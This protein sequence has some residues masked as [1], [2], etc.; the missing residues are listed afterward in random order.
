M[1]MKS[2]ATHA[3]ALVFGV[4]GALAAQKAQGQPMTLRGRIQIDV[5]RGGPADAP[6]SA[7][8][9]RLYMG[10]E[11]QFT[12][13]SYSVDVDFAD[14]DQE[15]ISLAD[16]TLVWNPEGRTRIM[17]GH[18]RP[19]A[20]SDMLTSDLDTVFVERAA[21]ADLMALGRMWGAMADHMHGNWGVQIGFFGAHGT[22][23]VNGDFGGA[24]LG[25]VRVHGNFLGG[26]SSSAADAPVLH[27]AAAVQFGDRPDESGFTLEP[28][29][30]FGYPAPET[31]PGNRRHILFTGLE[32]G[33]QH[34]TLTFQAEGGRTRVY[35]VS[36]GNPDLY[37]WYAQIAW[38]PTG[39]SRP[40]EAREGVFERVEPHNPLGNGG[41]GAIELGARIGQVDLNDRYL[42]GGRMTSYSTVMSWFPVKN[43]RLMA[44]YVHSD[45]RH[46]SA[47]DR[48]EDFVTLRAQYSW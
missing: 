4:Y 15:E 10:V 28:E 2:V 21:Y 14:F 9:R 27:M 44:N 35:A 12:N 7:Q 25:A 17:V 36:G 34:K 31:A 32:I 8:V 24:A 47:G 26:K 29:T 5:P 30:V 41:I 3:T 11:G 13:F 16:A 23:L 48:K 20:L 33:W 43:V 6:D 18:F 40:Y 39:E 37:G 22:E 45:S 1:T 46:D 19:P 38:R 42:H